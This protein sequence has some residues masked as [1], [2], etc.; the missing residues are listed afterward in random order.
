[1]SRHEFVLDWD[2]QPVPHLDWRAGRTWLVFNGFWFALCMTSSIAILGFGLAAERLSQDPSVQVLVL[3]VPLIALV[4]IAY[5]WLRRRCPLRDTAGRAVP[6]N[7]SPDLGRVPYMVPLAMFWMVGHLLIV[8]GLAVL[9]RDLFGA[10]PVWSG[11]VVGLAGFF[12]EFPVRILGR[13]P[14]VGAPPVTG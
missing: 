9:A 8:L 6:G 3:T 10:F 2:W 13:V 7:P 14:A 5:L 1:M 12:A 4:S 11:A